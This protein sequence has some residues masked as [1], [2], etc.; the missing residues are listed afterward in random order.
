MMAEVDKLDLILSAVTILT[1]KIEVMDSR[2]KNVETKLE[3]VDARLGVVETKVES[4]ES[5]L[6]TVESDLKS[7]KEEQNRINLIIENDIKR[8]ID[9]IVENYEPAAKVM[10]EKS[11]E[12]DN[13]KKDVQLL[14]RVVAEHSERLDEMSKSA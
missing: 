11:A 5:R 1:D 7:V 3:A 9:I 4:I 14:N 12:I 10:V 13:L 8:K 2:L 6:D